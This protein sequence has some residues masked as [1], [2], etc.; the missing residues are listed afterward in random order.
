MLLGGYPHSEGVL[1]AL[2]LDDVVHDL[3]HIVQGQMA[4]LQQQPAALRNALLQHASGVHLLTL[5][6]GDGTAL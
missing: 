3:L 6:H 5:T 4:V 1:N 2:G